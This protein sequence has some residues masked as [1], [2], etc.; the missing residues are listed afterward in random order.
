MTETS[1]GKARDM[2]KTLPLRPERIAVSVVLLAWVVL[3]F[4]HRGRQLLTM[5]LFQSVGYSSPGV[6]CSGQ[7]SERR[8]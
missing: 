1:A 3:H 6:G 8:Y 5:H 7:Q 4:R 2:A